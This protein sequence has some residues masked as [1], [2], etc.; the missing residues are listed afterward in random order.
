MSQSKSGE[1]ENTLNAQIFKIFAHSVHPKWIKSSLAEAYKVAA[2]DVRNRH[3]IRRL[4][5]ATAVGSEKSAASPTTTLE[6]GT[7]GVARKLYP[8]D[9]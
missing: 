2:F 3:L 9:V 5:P 7:D 1:H 8:S 4:V 6:P